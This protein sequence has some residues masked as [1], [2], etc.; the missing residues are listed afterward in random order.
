MQKTIG[1]VYI[2]R[3]MCNHFNVNDPVIINDAGKN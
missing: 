3:S 1:S 2:K